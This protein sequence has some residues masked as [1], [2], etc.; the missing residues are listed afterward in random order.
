MTFGEYVETLFK[1]GL[2]GKNKAKVGVTLF[3]A[4]DSSK[5]P[6]DA[7]VKTWM[8]GHR[9]CDIGRYFSDRSIKEDIFIE[10]LQRKTKDLALWKNIQEEFRKLKQKNS[11]DDNFLV[12]VETNDCNVFFWS[13]S[14]QFQN[15][16]GLHEPEQDE[17][18]PTMP[19]TVTPQMLSLVQIR[20]VFLN[21]VHRYKIM[22]II[23]RE[24]PIWNRTDSAIIDIFVEQMERLNLAN[25]P[26]NSFLCSSV[27][28]FVELLHIKMIE[29]DG[30]LN[31]TFGPDNETAS[32][33]MEGDENFPVEKAKALGIK[34][35]L[36]L[37]AGEDED[38]G[39]DEDDFAEDEYDIDPIKLLQFIQDENWGT[40]RK[41]MNLLLDN[42]S[43]WQD[44]A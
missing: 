36:E 39:D 43:S 7:A 19:V 14:K 16:F 30:N 18:N 13:L 38:Y 22:D 25:A 34:P 37:L 40:F 10:R 23:N 1:S 35:I 27:K 26:R 5:L 9:N 12:D 29:L 20:N 11:T 28:V 6:S 3:Y 31:I 21:A 17:N 32:F 24:P 44:E 15:I 42:I 41:K 4:A 2:F 33:N 8:K